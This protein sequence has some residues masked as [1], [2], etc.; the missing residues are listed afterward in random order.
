MEPKVKTSAGMETASQTVERIKAQLA[1]G[2]AS[3]S[4]T[5][6][7]TPTKNAPAPQ[8]NALIEALTARLTQQG[9]GISSSSSTSLQNSINEAITNT[10]IAGDLGSERLMSERNREVAFARDRAGA[11]YDTALEGRKGYATQVAA[12]RELTE[13]TEKSIRDLDKRYQEA[14]LANDSATAQRVADLQIKK[15]EFQQE[16]EQQFYNNMF[17]LASMEQQQNQFERGLSHDE[18][19]LEKQFGF[20]LTMFEKQTMRDERN[21]IMDW[22]AEYG[23]EVG[24]NDTMESMI[25]KISPFVDQKRQ[26]EL[27]ALRADINESNARTSAALK[28]VED[29]NDLDPVILD[30][31][32]M[33]YMNGQTQF[34]SGLKTTD[35][36]GQVYN[37]VQEMTR[38]KQSEL[39]TL[40]RMATSKEDFIKL[41]SKSDLVFSQ[42]DID[43]YS[44]LYASDWNK[45]VKSGWNPYQINSGLTDS[46]KI[47]RDQIN[48][49]T[50]SQG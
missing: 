3:G 10:Q 49:V 17:S 40:A 50:I 4:P 2:G 43:T 1:A 32:A 38:Q 36:L 7:T 30:A 42:T 31:M 6:P 20:D 34:M 35:Q 13:T 41:A 23:V 22:A 5:T 16:Q 33:A 29:T 9:Q 47:K 37:R 26:L 39:D 24:P 27:Q 12:L 46:E 25:S 45:K 18:A 21:K 15:L 28:E 44:N 19:M 11:T 14:I 8:S 48:G